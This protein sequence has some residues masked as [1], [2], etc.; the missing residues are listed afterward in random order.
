M[1]LEHKNK[2]NILITAEEAEILWNEKY[3]SSA[4]LYFRQDSS[5]QM[6]FLS[7]I[8]KPRQIWIQDN[9]WGKKSF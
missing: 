3:F 1:D 2:Y 4:N 7:I 5:P 8:D 9:W 6:E